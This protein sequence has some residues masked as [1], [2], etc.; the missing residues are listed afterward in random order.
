[1]SL[2]AFRQELQRGEK[3]II[4]TS[5]Y[6]LPTINRRNFTQDWF[7][8]LRAGFM[9]NLRPRQRSFNQ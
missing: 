8:S 6:P 4:K 2:F 5:S 7:D 9:F 1:M 3:M